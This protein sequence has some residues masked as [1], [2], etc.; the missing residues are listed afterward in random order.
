[1]GNDILV[2]VISLTYNHE[3]YIAK[4]IEGFLFQKTSF[5]YEVIVADDASTD[6]NQS[7]IKKYQVDAPD[8]IKPILREKN[9][10]GLNNFV[11]AFSKCTGK[12]IAFCEGDD[13]W[14]DPNKLQKQVDFLE[15]NAGFS[16]CA[17]RSQTLFFDGSNRPARDYVEIQR[18]IVFKGEFSTRIPYQLNSLLVRREVYESR[19]L[20]PMILSSDYALFLMILLSGNLY[21]FDD[22]MSIYR[23]QNTGMSYSVS[24]GTVK[25]DY[26]ILIKWLKE[27]SVSR[28]KIQWQK[29]LYFE[30]MLTYPSDID[31]KQI[32]YLYFKVV[33]YSML[34]FPF[35]LKKIYSLTFKGLKIAIN[36]KINRDKKL[37]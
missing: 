1:M 26:R 35:D 24:L 4:A 30:R 19:S 16:A 27:N 28:R 10:G 20:P 7:I 2:S 6:S 36:K 34:V 31:Y 15:E 23:V 14:T 25:A 3:K 18:N 29:R 21:V 11:D 13:Y 17:H 5:R 8:I 37:K 22:V 32:F 33:L 9:I 12:Y